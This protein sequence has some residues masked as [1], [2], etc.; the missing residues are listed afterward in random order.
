MTWKDSLRPASFRGVP[1]H[2][3]D[4]DFEGG[5]RTVTH[6]YPLRDEPYVEDLGRGA[7]T[8]SVDAYVIGENYFSARDRLR[9]ALEKPG[10]GDLVLP[11][12]GQQRVAATGFRIREPRSDGGM[13]WFSITFRETTAGPVYPR[14]SA[15]TTRGVSRI[16]DGALSVAA[17]VFSAVFSVDGQPAFARA[18]LLSVVSG[19][20]DALAENL[21]PVAGTDAG[22]AAVWRDI[23]AVRGLGEAGLEDAGELAAVLAQPLLTFR[24]AAADPRAAF[25][26]INRV[27]EYQAD[28]APAPGTATRALEA[29]NWQ[30]IDGYCRT[31]ACLEAARVAATVDFGYFEAAIS[32]RDLLLARL[33]IEGER[34]AD[35]LFGEFAAV[36]AQLVQAVPNADNAAARLVTYQPPIT[37]PSLLVTWQLYEGIDREADVIARN[38]I[39]HPGFVPGG[40][41]LEIVSRG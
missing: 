34:A 41:E 38:R 32:A 18:S 1:F 10:P 19:L 20:A 8:F 7:R 28:P 16:V 14:A 29:E 27:Y 36:R 4:Q 33:D 6:E 15:N 5:R 40:R 21:L 2:V 12:M 23:L 30:A 25:D 22:R 11:T 26:A 9:D 17:S 39:R 37:T 24:E 13:A 3:Q 31:L 35:E